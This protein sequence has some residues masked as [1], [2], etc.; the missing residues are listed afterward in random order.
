MVATTLQYLITHKGPL[1]GNGIYAGG[2]L[3]TDKRLENPDIAL[4]LLLWTVDP[5]AS[6]GSTIATHRFSGFT[7][8]TILQRPDKP[9]RGYGEE[10]GSF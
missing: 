7:L 3:K 1:S 2:Y 5:N 8:S 10:P 4:N 6:S 9:W